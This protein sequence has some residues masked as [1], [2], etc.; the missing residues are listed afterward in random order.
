MSVNRR[1]LLG[2][3]ATIAA[4]HMV[5]AQPAPERIDLWQGTPP[6]GAG[7]S[8]PEHV[9]AQ[10]SI[11]NV[12]RPRMIAYRPPQPNGAAAIVISGGGYAHLEAGKESTPACRWLQSNGVTAFE[13]IYRMPQDG[14][15]AA[16]PFQDAQ[17][18][19]RIIRAR[20]ASY[21]VD[22]ARIGAMGF[23]AGGHLAGMTG[24]RPAAPLYPHSDAVDALSA[25]PD[26]LALL[27][28]VLTMMPPFDRTHSRR[29]IVGEHPTE[30]QS[31][32]WSV[33]R[34]VDRQTPPTFLAQAADDP[35]SPIDNSLMMFAALR[36][37]H[38]PVEMHIFQAGRHGW[39][40]GKPA[41]EERAWPALFMAW[42]ELN[43][44]LPLRT[45]KG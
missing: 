23:S 3:A 26:F 37:A 12:S 6:G 38:V 27:Y 20:A 29:E 25:R 15:P 11:T 40:M 30:A 39:G 5:R 32:A 4:V 44:I 16:A 1:V 2:A 33:E 41:S 14:W 24:V 7:P 8:G 45:V 17:R 35:I 31:A 36:A 21:G 28:P 10:G 43:G 18:A 22:P 34:Q 9:T 19:M 42:A 13:L